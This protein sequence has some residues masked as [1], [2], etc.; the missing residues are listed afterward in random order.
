MMN[1]D[2]INYLGTNLK[3]HDTVESN[4]L[5]LNKIII[6]LEKMHITCDI[7]IIDSILSLSK[8]TSLIIDSI[9]TEKKE[10]LQN[11]GLSSI[12]N[13]Y[14]IQLLIE[15]YCYLNGIKIYEEYQEE[16]VLGGK[17]L[18]KEEQF[19]YIRRIQAGDK[20]AERIFVT[21]NLPLVKKVASKFLHRPDDFE[22]L[23]NEGIIGMVIAIKR[24]DISRDLKFST[25]AVWWIR[26]TI[27]RYVLRNQTM[28]KSSYHIL[29]KHIKLKK[30][31]DELKISLKRAPSLEEISEYTG[32]SQE[33]IDYIL[34]SAQSVASLNSE[35]NNDSDE[36]LLDFIPDDA[37][38]PEEIA[39]ENVDRE[40][41]INIIKSVVSER[42]FYILVLRYGLD[43]NKERTLEEVSKYVGVTRE[44]V[45][46]MEA[47]AF[48]KIRYHFQRN[49]ITPTF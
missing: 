17:V 21:M 25:Y 47:R 4:L 40:N 34:R 5:E 11:K 45:R 23:I 10:T 30:M 37:P 22:D 44:R 49:K 42:D 24:F 48:R 8:V 29:E 43:G 15:R 20:E 38:T 28:I 18:T 16:P 12:T 33:K 32:I 19:E 46:Q 6:Y 3:L 41:L 35:V 7:D 27:A 31:I 36:E 13:N 2:I 1:N 26:E 14:S 39:I 9:V